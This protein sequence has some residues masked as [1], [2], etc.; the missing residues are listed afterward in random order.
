MYDLTDNE[1][2]VPGSVRAEL[3]PLKWTLNGRVA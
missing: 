3:A 1:E 2:G